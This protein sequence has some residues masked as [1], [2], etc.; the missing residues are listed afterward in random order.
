MNT[1]TNS[2]SVTCKHNIFSSV[3]KRLSSATHSTHNNRNGGVSP[4]SKVRV[5][6]LLAGPEK[7]QMSQTY[8]TDFGTFR[9]DVAGTRGI[10]EQKRSEEV[11]KDLNAIIS[12]YGAAFLSTRLSSVIDCA[13][14]AEIGKGLM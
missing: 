3:E 5:Q 13:P 9:S 7:A 8:P 4:I 6:L 2:S 14:K 10:P 11:G 1:S 12:R